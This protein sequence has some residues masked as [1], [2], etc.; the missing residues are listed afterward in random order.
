LIIEDDYDAEYRYDRDPLTSLHALAPQSVLAAGSVSKSLSPALRLG[1]MVAPA[2]ALVELAEIK[3]N[4]DLGAATIPQAAL[5]HF[6]TSGAMDRHVRRSR[7]L[8]RRRRDA[9]V[10]TLRADVP[11]IRI[12]GIAAGLHVLVQL[13]DHGDEHAIADAARASGFVAQ[14]LARYRHAPGP[15]GLVLGYAARSP[16]DL[17]ASAR[18]LARHLVAGS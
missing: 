12:A 9:L 10:E 7:T 2:S 14:P 13:D 17:R 16:E 15:P 3:A 11:G 8:Y 5:A 6:I 18:V 4:I 1:W